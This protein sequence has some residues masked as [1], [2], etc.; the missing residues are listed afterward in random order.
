MS[1]GKVLRIHDTVRHNLDTRR[2]GETLV[3]AYDGVVFA[4]VSLD[5]GAITYVD[6][7]DAGSTYQKGYDEGYR[8]G[9]IDAHTDLIAAL[10][11][12]RDNLPGGA[13]EPIV[14]EPEA[15]TSG[16]E[17]EPDCHPLPHPYD[18]LDPQTAHSH[19]DLSTDSA[20][21]YFHHDRATF[22]ITACAKG[23]QH[24]NAGF[25]FDLRDPLVS[26]AVKSRALAE[27]DT[28]AEV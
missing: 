12:A 17:A 4:H 6:P 11:Y 23:H 14:E 9:R 5:T 19:A 10:E 13:P 21:R 2:E 26:D 22:H 1:D 18:E 3:F 27:W 16:V 24:T 25:S 28:R 15:S 20:R 8:Q 7:K